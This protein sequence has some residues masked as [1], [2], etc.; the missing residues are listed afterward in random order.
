MRNLLVIS[1]ATASTVVMGIAHIDLGIVSMGTMD[2]VHTHQETALTVMMDIA[3]IALET[4]LTVMMALAATG[5]GTPG[6]I[7]SKGSYV[8]TR[9]HHTNQDWFFS[10]D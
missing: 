7:L 5:Q 8:A 9:S 2:I 10:H 6:I 1:P 3:R 4:A